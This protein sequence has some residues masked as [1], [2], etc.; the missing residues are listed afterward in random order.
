[1]HDVKSSE[2]QHVYTMTT[3]IERHKH[4][5]KGRTGLDRGKNCLGG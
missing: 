3:T 5:D 1:M 4:K 2:K